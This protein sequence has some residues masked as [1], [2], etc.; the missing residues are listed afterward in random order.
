MKYLIVLALVGCA[1][2]SFTNDAH[3][4]QFKTKFNKL[5]TAEEESLRRTIFELNVVKI[6][7]HN[8][9]ADLGLKS[10][11]LGVNKFADMTNEEFVRVRNGLRTELKDNR[12]VPTRDFAEVDISDLPASVDWRTKGIVTPVKDQGQCG[13]CWAF[14]AVASLEGQQA[15]ATK[16][17]VSLSEQNLVDCSAAE[18]NDG[19]D[20]GLPD[21]GY[22]YI[23]DNKGIDT[24]KAYPYVAEDEQCAYLPKSRGATVKSFVD[25]A[26]G[27]ENALQKAS[28]T[29][30]PISVGID[31][32]SFAFQ[33][34]SGGVYDETDCSSTE[35]DHGVT[36]VGYGTDNGSDYWLVKNS[37]GEDWGLSGY[38]Q[39]SRN[40]ENQCGIASLASYPVV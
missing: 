35:L 29:I 27:D 40:K 26:E 34:Y 13:S 38:I 5:Y 2:A 12:Q 4:Q 30:G 8:I 37:W 20:G 39:M 28:A 33:L 31:A 11:R 24:E 10:Y 21:N 32:S 1:F 7:A 17:L 16:K 23:I 6:A 36:V 19:C 3:W 14:A 9:R 18:G 15:L 22:Q 25:I